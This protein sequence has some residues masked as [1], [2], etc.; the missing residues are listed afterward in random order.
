MHLGV[1]QLCLWPL[2][3]PR[4][5]GEGLPC[6]SSALLCQYP[7]IR[8][9]NFIKGNAPLNTMVLVMSKHQSRLLLLHLENLIEIRCLI[10][11]PT[12]KERC[13]FPSRSCTW[14]HRRW[15][16]ACFCWFVPGRESDLQN[17]HSNPTLAKSRGSQLT[18]DYVQQAS[19]LRQLQ[20]DDG[21]QLNF[22]NGHVLKKTRFVLAVTWTMVL[23]LHLLMVCVCVCVCV[24]AQFALSVYIQ[25]HTNVTDRTTS[26]LGVVIAVFIWSCS[27]SRLATLLPAA[28]CSATVFTSLVTT[29]VQGW[30][31]PQ[32]NHRR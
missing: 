7:S 29:A 1:F 22:L 30:Y 28:R 17:F 16:R 20:L 31:F 32:P 2:I 10:G 11:E 21:F 15:S 25:T 13:P 12:Q 6:L 18:P 14:M 23:R 9:Y 8:P 24:H 4:Y 3:A 26:F 27:L 19:K 5:L